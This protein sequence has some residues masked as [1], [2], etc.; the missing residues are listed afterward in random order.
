MLACAQFLTCLVDDARDATGVR[1]FAL[2][3]ITLSGQLILSPYD[4]SLTGASL[5]FHIFIKIGVKKV[6]K[7]SLAGSLILQTGLI[8][9]NILNNLVSYT[10][11]IRENN[12]HLPREYQQNKAPDSTHRH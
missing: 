7:Y 12:A 6:W 3:V 9:T 8:V 2:H 1:M 5:Y 4:R 11:E 10:G